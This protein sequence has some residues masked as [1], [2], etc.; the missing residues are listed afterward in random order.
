MTNDTNETFPTRYH[1][2]AKERTGH[3]V[4]VD[5]LTYADALAY[6]DAYKEPCLELRIH[7]DTGQL[8]ESCTVAVRPLNDDELAHQR[9]QAAAEFLRMQGEDG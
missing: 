5:G 6:C 4:V 3:H 9:A 2:I 1:V 7:D 8:V